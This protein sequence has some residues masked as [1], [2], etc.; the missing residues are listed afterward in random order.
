[1]GFRFTRGRSLDFCGS[2]PPWPFVGL[3]RGGL[4]KCGYFLSGAMGKGV[5]PILTG[6][7]ENA[8]NSF[9]RG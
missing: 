6:E 4:P 8:T 2:S 9:N 3:V 5:S 1:M 7:K